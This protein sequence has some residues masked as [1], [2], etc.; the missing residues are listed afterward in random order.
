MKLKKSKLILVNLLFTLSLSTGYAQTSYELNSGWKC[1][2]AGNLKNT[3]YELSNTKFSIA[4]WM[5]A[6]VPGTVLTTLLYN[7]KVP[8]PFFGMNNQQ[9][10]DIYKTGREYY[11][12]WFVK[13][14]R[15]APVQRGEQVY[16]NFRG[17]NYSCNIYLNGHK[18]NKTAQ[19]GMFLRFNYNITSYL[20]KTGS[21]RLAVLVYPPDVAGN[22]NGGQGGDGTIARNVGLQYTAGWDWIQPV[23]DRNTGIWDKVTIEKTGPVRITDT[24]IITLVP[25]IRLPQGPQKPAIIQVSTELNN[26]SAVAVTGVLKYELDGKIISKRVSLKPMSSQSVSFDDYKLQN[27]KLWWPNGYGPQDLYDIKVSLVTNGQKVSDRRVLKIGV[28]Q[29]SSEF[30][31]HTGS[32]QIEVNGQ[33]IFIKGGNWIISDEMLRLSDKRYDAEV[34]FHRDMNLNLIRVWGGAMIERPEFYDACDKYGILVFQ[35]LWGS[36]DCNGRWQ[37]PMKLD[38][39]WARRKYPDD[40]KLFLQSAEDQIKMVRNHASLAIWCGGNEI[41]PPED[42]LTALRDTILPRLDNTRWFVDYSNS[43]SMS[44]NTLGGNG[45]GPYGIQPLS[46]FWEHRTFPF[47]SEVGSVGLSD[48]ESLKRFI[49]ANNLISPVYDEVT[50]KTTTDSVWDYHKYIGYDTS[51]SKYGKAKNAEDFAFK[52]QLVNYDQYRGLAEGFS[53]HMWDW[54]TGFI[55]WKTQNPWTAMRGQMYD[56]YLDPNACLYGLHNGSEPLHIMY[57]PVNGMVMAVNNTFKARRSMMLVVKTYDMAGRENLLTQVFADIGPTTS[58]RYFSIKSEIDK[59]AA[60]EGVFL[61]LQLLDEEKKPITE[62]LYWIAD[63]TGNYSGLQKMK[64]SNLLAKARSIHPGLV[65]VTLE[66]GKNNTSAFFNRI[67]LVDAGAGSRLLPVFYSDNYVTI[68][69]GEKKTIIVD[70]K[71]INGK[72]KSAIAINGWNT[73][74]RLVPIDTN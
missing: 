12:Y 35:D 30:N 15:E 14:F 18:L 38:D 19:K 55:I 27:P 60:K 64:Q 10:Q 11:T 69:P 33:K 65:E 37:D 40:H 61:S 43:D 29:L 23:R 68:L 5:P 67:S 42:I 45:D 50:R 57:N 26:A 8:D 6:V 51:I 16:L 62:N 71:S 56:Y 13:D 7:Q 63:H 59:I 47:N 48:Y 21:N 1:A 24:H 20:G 31:E 9:I 41:T 73:E 22:P 36:G 39:Q 44:H 53:S 3:G 34:R 58:K 28:R 74:Q 49:P 17:V 32:R 2:P 46:I 70:C 66:N 25:G 4:A 72:N 54:Y 52:A